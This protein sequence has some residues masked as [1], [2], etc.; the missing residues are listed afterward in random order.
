MRI[1]N[2]TDTYPPHN[3]GVATTLYA[4]H[5]AKKEWQDE[6]FGALESPD[7]NKVGGVPFALYPDYRIAL[8]RGALMRRVK[9]FDVIHN[10]TPYGMFYYGVK[11]SRQLDK[12]LVGTFHT[13]PA[14]VFG[15]LITTES[16]VGKVATEVTWRYLI[17]LYNECDVVVTVSGWLD[18]ELRK[19]GLKAPTALIPNGIDATKFNPDVDAAAFR[20]AYGIPDK[21]MAL[22]VGRLQHK[23]DPETFVRA[24]IDCKSDAIFV[25]S[26]VGELEP[27]LKEIV[28]QSGKGDKFKFLGR[29]PGDMLPRAYAAADAFVMPSEMETQGVVVLEAMACGTPCIATDVGIAREVI[30]PEYIIGFK[31]HKGLSERLDRLLS[32]EAEKKRLTGIVRKRIEAEYTIEAM[33]RKLG[34]L[35]ECQ[36]RGNTGKKR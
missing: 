31:D 35:Y 4:V 1:A 27:H 25:L 21:P 23:K 8:D 32:D 7:V 19:R 13:D 15:A 5:H 11:A 20:K 22:F 14:A 28:A 12:P 18:R 33:L 30:D 9:D 34:T 6:L 2:F 26:G 10:H 29:L 16:P 36:V 17:R 3:N 24:G